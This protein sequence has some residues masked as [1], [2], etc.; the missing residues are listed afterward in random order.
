[1]YSV[2]FSPSVVSNSLR[3]HVWLFCDPNSLWLQ[4]AGLPCPSPTPGAYSNSCPLS[5]WCQPTISSSPFSSI[6]LSSHV[7]SFSASGSFPMSQFFASGGQIIEV[8]APVLPMNIQDWFPLLSCINVF[9]YIK[10]CSVSKLYLTLQSHGLQHARLPYPSLSCPSLSQS[11][12][13]LCPSSRWYHSTIS[14]SAAPFPSCPQ[15]FPALALWWIIKR[16]CMPK[17]PTVLNPLFRR[18]LNQI[19][20]SWIFVCF[21]KKWREGD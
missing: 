20:P 19:L 12:L 18:K 21:V 8:S 13:K 9:K 15:S 6:P 1:M 7:Q 10:C 11:L 5:Q 3:P 14:F 16:Q 2:Q 4:H 17:Q